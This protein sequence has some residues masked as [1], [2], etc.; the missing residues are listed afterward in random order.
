VAEIGAPY[1]LSLGGTA[2]AFNTHFQFD[3]EYIMQ[4]VA[5]LDGAPVRT[6]VEDKPVTDGGL[7]FD[8]YD[9]ARH[10]TFTG[11]IDPGKAGVTQ[12]NT[13]EANLKTLCKAM[14]R[15][16]GQLTYSPTGQT[17]Q[18][19]DVRCDVQPTFPGQGVVKEF[20]FGLVAA[21]PDPY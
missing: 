16:D 17:V 15:Q 3:Y 7:V 4:D 8:F 19:F 13:M 18:H 1:T 9:A 21:N 5:G 14:K 10:M 2:I 11:L 12:R 20:I 6:P